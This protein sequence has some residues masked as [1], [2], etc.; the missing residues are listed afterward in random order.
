MSILL[1][2]KMLK[3][4]VTMKLIITMA[5]HHGSRGNVPFHAYRTIV[6]LYFSV[7]KRGK[8]GAQTLS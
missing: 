8:S 4:I 1:V 5:L 6:C 7:P 3:G 2:T